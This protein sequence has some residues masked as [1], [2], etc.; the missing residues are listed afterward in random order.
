MDYM[1]F[2]A[3]ADITAVENLGLS[4]GY[5]GYM[6]T[7]NASGVDSVLWNGIDLRA[8]W[9]GIPGLS[10]S[11]HNNFS[12][13]KGVENDWLGML[14]GKDSYFLTVYNAVGATKELTE[15][16][17]VNA[18][19]GNVFSHTD[20]GSSGEI[21]VDNLWVG[22]K[23][24]AKVT[25]HAEFEAGLKADVLLSTADGNYSAGDNKAIFSIPVGIAIS[26]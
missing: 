16:F 25:E 1:T 21:K 19:I 8:A 17:S 18:E 26:F 4:L 5:T 23:L 20:N 22:A 13:A 14:T 11:V 24:I 6:S 3:Y 9:T 7:S 15:K 12:F 10:I 2:G